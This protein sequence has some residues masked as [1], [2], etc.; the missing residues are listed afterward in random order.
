MQTSSRRYA[1]LSQYCAA[2]IQHFERHLRLPR[3]EVVVDHRPTW[4]IRRGKATSVVQRLHVAL[5]VL[6]CIAN[7]KE[8]W[9]CLLLGRGQLDERTD[10]VED[11]HPSSIRTD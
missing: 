4:R 2:V 3:R 8:R 6:E 7:R 9:P 10:V 11:P 1:Q 5:A